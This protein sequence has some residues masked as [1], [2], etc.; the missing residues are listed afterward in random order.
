MGYV[1]AWK[2]K[3]QSK[4]YTFNSLYGIHNW[5]DQEVIPQYLRILPYAKLGIFYEDRSDKGLQPIPWFI[6]QGDLVLQVQ[7]GIAKPVNTAEYDYRLVTHV[8][9]VDSR[10]WSAKIEVIETKDAVILHN[11]TTSTR[12]KSV[13]LLVALIKPGGYIR[14]KENDAPYRGGQEDWIYRI[15]TV[16]H[17]GNWKRQ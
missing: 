7:G 8:N 5:K 4:Q 16:S 12:I 13:A 14:F 17:K 9:R 15:L 10:T 3:Q 2:G 6:E 1:W 11:A